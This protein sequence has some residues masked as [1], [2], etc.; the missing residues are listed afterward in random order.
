[1]KNLKLVL[2][3]AVALTLLANC[4]TQATYVKHPADIL[5]TTG[6]VSSPYT[7]LG[8]IL[9]TKT[10]GPIASSGISTIGTGFGGGLYN[11]KGEGLVGDLEQF[12]VQELVKEAK[13]KGG[14][15][16]VGVKFSA[17]SVPLFFPYIGPFGLQAYTVTGEVIS[18][19]GSATG[20]K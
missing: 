18:I 12:L 10:D 5:V 14:N 1:M 13:A 6:H 11:A 7:S 17:A 16:V 20:K 4:S 15:A 2:V 19:P 3:M 8:S 9:I